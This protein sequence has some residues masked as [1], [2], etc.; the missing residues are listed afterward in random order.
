[1]ATFLFVPYI[2]VSYIFSTIIFFMAKAIARIIISK[3]RI[4]VHDCV[5]PY[6]WKSLLDSVLVRK[7]CIMWNILFFLPIFLNLDIFFEYISI[8][9]GPFFAWL[10]WIGWGFFISIFLLFIVTKT[11]LVKWWSLTVYNFIQFCRDLFKFHVSMRSFQLISYT[12]YFR[13]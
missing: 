10:F 5:I 4:I 13:F 8:T 11:N 12:N 7:I 2:I 6:W 3:E 1:M 9:L